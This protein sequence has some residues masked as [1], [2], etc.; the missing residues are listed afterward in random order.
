[1]PDILPADTLGSWLI[2]T[3]I[4]LW[5]MGV[6]AGQFV[7]YFGLFSKSDPRWLHIYISGLAFLSVVKSCVNF[8]LLWHKTIILLGDLDGTAA[9]GVD[10]TLTGVVGTLVVSTVFYVQ[11]YY[12]YRLFL[13]SNHNAY[14]V[15]PIALLLFVGW[16]LIIVSNGLFIR[17]AR[18]SDVADDEE[19]LSGDVILTLTTAFFL[20]R[21]RRNV[22]ASSASVLTTLIRLT[23]HT[24]AP[25]TLT[26]VIAC[27][28]LHNL[29]TITCRILTNFIVGVTLPNRSQVVYGI[30]VVLGKLWV[31]SLMWMLNA[32]ADKRSR[33]RSVYTSRDGE[34]RTPTA[35]QAGLVSTVAF[36]PWEDYDPA[37]LTLARS[38]AKQV[39][40]DARSC[41]VET[42]S[43]HT[44]SDMEFAS[45]TQV[46][47]SRCGCD[48]P[49][50]G[51][52]PERA[53]EPW[54]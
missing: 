52:G 50:V 24:A 28:W 45:A 27:S 33:M 30:N 29:L 5:F 9:L 11:G 41:D 46:R 6:L 17:G 8:A 47:V 7:K 49:E 42:G 22:L 1:M 48:E 43:D 32:R 35:M 51:D 13:I 34:T 18:D 40:S 10:T 15:V 53:R 31:F 19:A 25:A 14:I 20:L 54:R 44:V 16:L 4:E 2:G 36:R 26:Y 39:S 38:I 12:L 37:P 21:F 23:F 3:C